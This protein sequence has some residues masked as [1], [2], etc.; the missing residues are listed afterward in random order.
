MAAYD[1]AGTIIS[2]AAVE[3][4]LTPVADPFAS[5]APEQVQLCTLLNMCGRELWAKT[6]W[7]QFVRAFSID[8]TTDPITPGGNEYAFPSDYGYW[9]NQTG[10]TPN[11]LG[12]GLPLGGPLSEQQWT[13]VV[14]QNLAAST[15][16]ISFKIGNDRIQILPNPPPANTAITFEYMSR[17][18]VQPTGTTLPGDRTDLITASADTVLFESILMVKML[19]ARYKEAKGID[20][21]SSLAQFAAAYQTA[22]SINKPAPILNT[23]VGQMFPLINVWTNTPPTGFGS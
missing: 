5:S 16:Y 4:G 3:C 8:T 19:A 10:W 13:T 14:A 12:L 18:W 20:A 22:T 2:F 15:I 7:Q 23:A 1:T 9:I 6:Q 17:A 11:N 21:N